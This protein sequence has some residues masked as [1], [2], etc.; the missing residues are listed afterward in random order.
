MTL[1]QKNDIT[2]ELKT[3]NFDLDWETWIA[4]HPEIKVSS[5]KTGKIIVDFPSE[6]FLS[7]VFIS[8]G[9]VCLLRYQLSEESET[10]TFNPSNQL[11]LAL[12]KAKKNLGI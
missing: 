12:D 10:I 9:K 11:Y 3:M 6:V 4:Q 7:E 1:A 2:Q 5:D 8:N